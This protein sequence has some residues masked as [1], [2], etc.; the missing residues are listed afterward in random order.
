MN[1]NQIVVTIRCLTYNHEPYIR[2]CLDG[3]VMQKTNFKFEAIVH[4][5]AS[6][7][8]T[9]SI[10]REYAEKY[11]DIIKP[12]FET[13]NQYSKKDGSLGRIMD[14]HTRGKYVAMCEG[15]DYWTDPLKLQKQVDFL[16]S[17]PEYVMCSHFFQNFIQDSKSFS[18]YGP[19][20]IIKDKSYDF[21]YYIKREAWITHPLS[22][23]YRKSALNSSKYRDCILKKD[24][25]LFYFLLK[26]GKGYLMKDIMAVY[27]KHSGG[28]WSGS[29]RQKRISDDIKYMNSI[30]LIEKNLA[31]TN[32]LYNYL[33]QTGYLGISFLKKESHTY[34]KVLKTIRKHMGIHKTLLLLIRNLK[35]VP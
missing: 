7:D 30:Y 2:Q 35:Y 32:L 34:I 13:E 24:L 5:D 17:H 6:T 9:A 22:V 31:S 26:Q 33:Y 10:I 14:A 20:C 29:S 15:D 12:I 11:P 1:E 4:D 18:G 8:G 19:I 21:D 27:R 25:T 16:E 23:M 28:V 3:F